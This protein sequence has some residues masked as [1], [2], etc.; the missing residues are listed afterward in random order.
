MR[1]ILHPELKR[2]P[3]A[4]SAAVVLLFALLA[5]LVLSV[6]QGVHSLPA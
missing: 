2:G 6:L 4:E 5:V 3:M 1:R